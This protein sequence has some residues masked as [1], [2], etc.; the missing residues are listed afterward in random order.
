M[1]GQG[2]LADPYIVDNWAD[3]VTA[4]ST[5]GAYVEF[6]DTAADKVID[7][8]DDPT[9][10][11]GIPYN[12]IIGCADIDFNGWEIRNPTFLNGYGIRISNGF[13]GRVIRGMR[14]KSAT[15]DRTNL[16]SGYGSGKQYTTYLDDANVSVCHNNGNLNIESI[17]GSAYSYLHFRRMTCNIKLVGTA[18]SS[19]IGTQN[20]G[21][22]LTDCN[23][24]IGGASYGGTLI[25]Y[26]TLSGCCIYGSIDLRGNA[27]IGGTMDNCI[28][29]PTIA[30]DAAHTLTI[31]STG[32][33][34]A[35]C[36]DIIGSDVTVITTGS[37]VLQ[38]T[39]AQ[40]QSASYLTAHGIPC[41]DDRAV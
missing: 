17:C 7:L 12:V 32:T 13:N 5:S 15:T 37:N 14:I 31:G 18:P 6:D 28:L 19:I 9:L 23:I 33:A 30:A 29:V 16:I 1:T 10:C 40:I 22:L 24:K 11:S 41:V 4:F 36:T 25:G 21:T 38:M 2:T 8:N 26:S 34:S 27:V 39:T 3:M 35:I 20:G